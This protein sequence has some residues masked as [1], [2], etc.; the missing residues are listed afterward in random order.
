MYASRRGGGRRRRG[1]REERPFDVLL[2]RHARQQDRNAPSHAHLHHSRPFDL[3]YMQSVPGQAA[4][5]V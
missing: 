1:G 3:R 2:K 5:C 4:V